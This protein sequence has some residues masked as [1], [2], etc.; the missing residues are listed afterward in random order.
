MADD[1]EDQL[2]NLIDG[3]GD[4]K[5][6][7]QSDVDKIERDYELDEKGEPQANDKFANLI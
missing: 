3:G 1:C 5:V 7:I 6:V 2:D 4:R